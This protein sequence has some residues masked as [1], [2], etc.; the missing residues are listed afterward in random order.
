MRDL[1][2]LW[3]QISIKPVEYLS[4]SI[5]KQYKKNH[6]GTVTLSEKYEF[7]FKPIV[8]NGEFLVYYV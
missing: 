6:I 3:K 5:G 8:K 2:A 1:I 7:L 4:S